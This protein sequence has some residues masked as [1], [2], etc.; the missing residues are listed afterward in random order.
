MGDKVQGYDPDGFGPVSAGPP[1]RQRGCLFYGCILTLVAGAL[2]TLFVVIGFTLLYRYARRTVIENTAEAPVAIPAPALSKA[3]ADAVQARWKAFEG[4]VRDG[5][6]ATIRLDGDELHALLA[7]QAGLRDRVATQIVGDEIRAQMSVPFRFPGVGPRY[8]NGEGVAK[9]AIEGG[10]LVVTLADLEVNGRPLPPDVAKAVEG[11]NVAEGM[12]LKVDQQ[13][14]VERVES[15]TVKDGIL[16]IVARPDP[17]RA[18]APPQ[19]PPPPEL[20]RNPFADG[21]LEPP[22][23]PIPVPEPPFPPAAAP[24]QIDVRTGSG[25]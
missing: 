16:T 8:L 14:L 5:R 24:I 7:E 11:R 19:P 23:E 2:M 4:A 20:P 25:R 1:P 3:Q 22:T 9:P 13:R 21:I 12:E 15:L 6:A 10:R 18:N 17:S